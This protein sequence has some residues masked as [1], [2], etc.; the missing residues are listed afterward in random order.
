M[1]R[2]I[3]FFSKIRTC[4]ACCSCFAK[5]LLR[6]R[7]KCIFAPRNPFAMQ[8]CEMLEQTT[9]NEENNKNEDEHVGHG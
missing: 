9:K 7:S 1:Q 2:R 3:S 8:S 6:E 4:F 5:V